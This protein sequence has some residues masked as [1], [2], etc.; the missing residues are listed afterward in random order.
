MKEKL[1]R[2]ISESQLEAGQLLVVKDCAICGSVRHRFMLIRRDDSQC[3]FD[4]SV[5][6]GWKEYPPIHRWAPGV[7]LLH[8]SLPQG[9]LFIVDTGLDKEADEEEMRVVEGNARYLADLP[10]ARA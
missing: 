6:Q 2:V 1:I 5:H 7:C 9:R 10:K 3:T 8:W 4:D